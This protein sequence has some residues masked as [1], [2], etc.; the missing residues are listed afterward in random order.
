MSTYPHHP[1][2]ADFAECL[3]RKGHYAGHAF[4]KTQEA[5]LRWLW[6]EVRAHVL[7]PYPFA[8]R[9]GLK[10]ALAYNDNWYAPHTGINL[11]GVYA[12]WEGPEADYIYMPVEYAADGDREVLPAAAPELDA[13]FGFSLADRL[14]YRPP[15]SKDPNCTYDEYFPLVKAAIEEHYGHYRAPLLRAHSLFGAMLHDFREGYFTWLFGYSAGVVFTREGVEV[16]PSGEYGSVW[17]PGQE[18]RY[19]GLG[20]AAATGREF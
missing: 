12:K 18:L 13:L 15:R 5:E 14:G 2:P 10:F 6:G 16:S 3:V 20:Y 8:E 1:L 4:A 19:R 11:D 9:V 7:D 17:E